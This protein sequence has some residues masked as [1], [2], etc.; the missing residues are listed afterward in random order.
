[1]E[2]IPCRLCGNCGR[3]SGLSVQVCRCGA[4][5]AKVPGRLVDEPIP[6]ERCGEIDRSLPVFVQKCPACGEENFTADPA[7]PVRLC[8]K[9]HKARVALITPSPY[10]TEE[11]P[12]DSQTGQPTQTALYPD[13]PSPASETASASAEENDEDGDAAHWRTVLEGVRS[14]VPGA[15]SSA[16][17]DEYGD[18][19]DDDEVSSWSSLLG[20]SAHPAPG[21]APAAALAQPFAGRQL[22]LTAIR[23]GPLSVTLQAGQKG[24]PFLLGRSA[25]CGEFLSQDLRVSNEHCYLTFQNGSWIVIDNHSANGTAVNQ[26]FLDFNGQRVL[27]DGDELT[28][29]HH[30]D[31]MAFR[32]SI[33]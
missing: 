11:A 7:H 5:L 33:R 6:P 10:E 22:T 25:G 26:Q 23:Y 19:E 13:S 4:D 3:Y 28:L 32:V 29:G 24:L 31:S 17:A 2:K 15:V 27:Q 9:C 8:Y 1:M 12:P 21:P 16:P 14:S 18:D 30:P 20:G